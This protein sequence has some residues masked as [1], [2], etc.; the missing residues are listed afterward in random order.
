MTF[1]TECFEPLGFITLHL[2]QAGLVY[3]DL[4]LLTPAQLL[5]CVYFLDLVV[6]FTSLKANRPLRVT[7]D[8]MLN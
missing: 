8:Y 2:L 7:S 3:F 1:G 5:S 6:C 4:I